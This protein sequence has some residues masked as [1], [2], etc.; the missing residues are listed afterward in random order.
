MDGSSHE[1][2]LHQAYALKDMWVLVE[3]EVAAGT[4]DGP[5]IITIDALVA[6]V[7]DGDAS[8][9][10]LKESVVE[11][12]CGYGNTDQCT[13]I[14]Y[15]FMLCCSWCCMYTVEFHTF[16]HT[17]CIHICFYPCHYYYHSQCRIP[18]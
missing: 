12:Y 15:F 8:V 1:K 2:L 13:A 4:I 6:S 17:T 3:R 10:D 5:F 14:P 16:Y 11:F 7:Q 9:D 18:V